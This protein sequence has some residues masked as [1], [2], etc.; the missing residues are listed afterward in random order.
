[1]NTSYDRIL[2]LAN[3]FLI[4]YI[5]FQGYRPE[6]N[7][8]CIEQY[9][10]FK[11]ISEEGEFYPQTKSEPKYSGRTLTNK[12][13]DYL[14]T[15]L[16]NKLEILGVINIDILSKEKVFIVLIQYIKDI[17]EISEFH[18]MKF[19]ENICLSKIWRK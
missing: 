9:P 14:Y 2:S 16:Y 6:F 18:S 4:K 12:E 17:F 1:M 13:L 19:I 8:H 11:L 15:L 7:Y 3:A 10:F 5:S